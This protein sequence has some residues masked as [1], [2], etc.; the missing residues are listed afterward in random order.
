MLETVSQKLTGIDTDTRTDSQD[1]VWSGTDLDP[2][3]DKEWLEDGKCGVES[4]NQIS[5]LKK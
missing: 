3:A 4:S 2:S 1:R 5:L